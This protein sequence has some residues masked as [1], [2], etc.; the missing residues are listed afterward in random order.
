MLILWVFFSEQYFFLFFRFFIFIFYFILFFLFLLFLFFLIGRDGLPYRCFYVNFAKFLRTPFL[1]EHLWW[2]L[3][4]LFKYHATI[5]ASFF[6]TPDI[7][8][9]NRALQNTNSVNLQKQLPDVFHKKRC[10]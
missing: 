2:L 5:I 3:L 1:T 8:K 9:N 10:S 7:I 4:K 6:S